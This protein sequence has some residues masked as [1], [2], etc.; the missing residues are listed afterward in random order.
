MATLEKRYATATEVGLA[1]RILDAVLETMTVTDHPLVAEALQSRD[2]DTLL[3]MIKL[4]P[5]GAV[6]A[7]STFRHRQLHVLFAWLNDAI[8]SEYHKS[9]LTDVATLAQ[10]YVSY[11]T[12]EDLPPLDAMALVAA[13]SAEPLEYDVEM[14]EV[15]KLS[16]NPPAKTAD[17]RLCAMIAIPLAVEAVL[18]RNERAIHAGEDPPVLNIT[19]E[20]CQKLRGAQRAPSVTK[21]VRDMAKAVERAAPWA[22]NTVGRAVLAGQLAWDEPTT[23]DLNYFSELCCRSAV[24]AVL[25]T[26]TGGIEDDYWQWHLAPRVSSARHSMADTVAR[27]QVILGT[28]RTLNDEILADD[29]RMLTDWSRD[30]LEEFVRAT[31]RQQWARAG[32]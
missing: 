7:S 13:S 24:G 27:R 3:E 17:Q 6:L 21:R 19:W 22:R 4:D 1:K 5:R 25:P 18:L 14:D 29:Y 23:P 30:T 32:A 10:L 8:P 28:L 11:T 9:M 31:V 20:E 15:L 2:V 26:P 12:G 16:Q